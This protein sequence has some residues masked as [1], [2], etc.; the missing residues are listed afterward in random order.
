MYAQLFRASA[1]CGGLRT[2]RATGFGGRERR[3]RGRVGSVRGRVG[4]IFVRTVRRLQ[5]RCPGLARRSLFC[6]VLRCLHLSASAVGFY[7]EIRDGRTLAREGCHVGGRVDPRA[8]S[9]VF[10]RDSPS[11]KIL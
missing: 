5:R 4:R 7:V 3:G 9:V 11:R 8:F 6:Y 10:G 2:V 1:S